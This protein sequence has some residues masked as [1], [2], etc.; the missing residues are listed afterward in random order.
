[1]HPNK[2]QKESSGADLHEQALVV[3]HVD[4][5]EL[6]A[7]VRDAVALIPEPTLRAML[8]CLS[9]TVSQETN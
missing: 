4:V 5:L 3:D 8:I 7:R 2:K 9:V 6:A 1:M